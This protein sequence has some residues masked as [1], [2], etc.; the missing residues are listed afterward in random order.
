[1]ENIVD[2]VNRCPDGGGHCGYNSLLGSLL[3][4]TDPTPRYSACLKWIGGVNAETPFT[5]AD[6]PE[7]VKSQCSPSCVWGTCFDGM[8]ICYDGYTGQDCSISADKYLDCASEYTQFGINLGKSGNYIDKTLIRLYFI[9]DIIGTT[10]TLL[11]LDSWYIHT[12]KVLG[13]HTVLCV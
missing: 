6:L 1:M 4:A 8:C 11:I 5:S 3:E 12:I 10:K 7:I 9:I 13:L 2:T